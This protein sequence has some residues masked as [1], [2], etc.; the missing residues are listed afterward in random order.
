VAGCGVYIGSADNAHDAGTL[1]RYGITHIVNM[2]HDI[3][4][5]FP[6]N[7]EYFNA[8]LRDSID[9]TSMRRMI[10]K[11]VAFI[12]DAKKKG[13]NVLVHCRF[14]LSRAGTATIAYLVGGMGWKL[15]KACGEAVGK[16]QGVRPNKS[17]FEDLLHWEKTC[18]GTNSMIQRDWHRV[19]S[20]GFD[21]T[22][23]TAKLPTGRFS[24]VNL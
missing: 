11:I 24:H 7:A 21:G 13:G 9:E 14:G 8:N 17:F 16:R 19:F 2:T 20:R 4:N 15:E 1:K 23:G 22:G 10:P 5:A 6:E 18:H 3:P 12:T